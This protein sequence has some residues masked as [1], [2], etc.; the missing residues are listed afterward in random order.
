MNEVH[1]QLE[2]LTEV[3]KQAL[4]RKE[5]GSSRNLMFFIRRSLAQMRLRNEWDESEILVEAYMRTRKLIEAGEIIENFPGYLTRV[6]QFIIFEKSRKRKRNHGIHQKLSGV[7]SE[8]AS[9]SESPYEEGIDDEIINSLW[10]SFNSLPTKDRRILT[11]RIIK[12]YSW[13]EI[14]YR[15][16]ES[17]IE[18]SYDSSLPAKLRKQGERALG[19]LRKRILSIDNQ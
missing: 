7:K 6:S 12:G 19:K 8:V 3:V 17:G 9:L 15:L 4:S 18:K 16:I 14:S 1:K 2:L 10:S 13:Q 5:N 11:L